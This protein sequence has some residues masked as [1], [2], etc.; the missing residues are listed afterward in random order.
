MEWF[1]ALSNV[2]IVIALLGVA[3]IFK[4]AGPGFAVGFMCGAAV[5]CLWFRGKHGHW[6]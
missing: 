3:A 1:F 4:F 2:A 6:P 5:F